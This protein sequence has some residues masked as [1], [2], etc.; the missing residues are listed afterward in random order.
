MSKVYENRLDR[1]RAGFE[2][3]GIDAL[4]LTDIYNIGY[5][6]GTSGRDLKILVTK[7]DAWI[8]TDFRYR[9]MAQGLIWLKYFEVGN[10]GAAF[11]DL[12][13]KLEFSS[14]GIERDHIV[15]GEYLQVKD[16]VPG[17]KLVPITGLVE[18]L[19]MIKDEEELRR[20]AAAEKLGDEGFMHMLGFIKEGMTESE[21]AAELEYYMR[22]HG[23][24][25]L[26]FST[27]AVSGPNSS[28]PHGVPGLR[29][30]QKGDFLTLDFGCIVEGYC[31]DM[32]R[33]VAIGEP[34]EEMR[35][36]Y[37]TV[38]KAQL[39]ACEKIR[40]GL[41]GI[42]CDAF[43]R[44]IITEAGYGPY[45]GHSLGH[46]VGLQVH[47]MPRFSKLYSGTIAP[48]TVVSIEP[49]IYLPGKFGVRI[50]DLAIITADGIINL[51]CS[52]KELIIL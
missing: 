1:I 26:S 27:I 13:K 29:K 40:A 48:N 50:E 25:G 22:S 52:P 3:R 41:T 39:N 45:F 35:K 33:T 19:R 12:L 17:R 16:A 51:A 36:V 7:E 4:L 15:L 42:Q 30:L 11:V 14:L 47:E 24:S 43:A 5:V 34:T 6:T 10:G 49:G 38:L 18:D 32:T 23:A 9:E 8:I 46:G 44:D 21:I 28:Y 31:S 20:I 2:S 37:D